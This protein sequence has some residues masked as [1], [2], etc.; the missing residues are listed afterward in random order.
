MFKDNF[1]DFSFNTERRC[2]RKSTRFVFHYLCHK[3][4]LHKQENAFHLTYIL[5]QCIFAISILT[6]KKKKSS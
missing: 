6:A 3:L 1:S 4:N 2:S 5:Y